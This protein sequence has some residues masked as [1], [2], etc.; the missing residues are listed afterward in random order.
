MLRLTVSYGR[1][2]GRPEF[3]SESAECG[4]QLDLESSWLDDATYLQE[5][6]KAAYQMCVDA[7][8]GQLCPA[9]VHAA[10]PAAVQAPPPPAV[11]APAR[12]E[13]PKNGPVNR[14]FGAPTTV[15]TFLG[16]FGKQHQSIKD[17]VKAVAKDRGLP[18]MFKEWAD[19]D[20]RSV[21]AAV[22]APPPAAVQAPPS[23]YNGGSDHESFMRRCAI[24]K[25]EEKATAA[26]WAAA[27]AMNG[28]GRH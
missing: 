19:D 16:W 24:K 12:Q 5:R 20:A 7:V 11:H 10:P 8:D 15:K 4:L 26:A 22:M 2:E 27:P 1:R 28:N 18:S 13:P 23:Q 9:P 17:A 14:V 3:S 21:Y 6:I 25:A